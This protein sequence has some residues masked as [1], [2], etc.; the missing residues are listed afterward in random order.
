MDNRNWIGALP[1][2]AALLLS[3]ACA[4]PEAAPA[5]EM[6]AAEQLSANAQKALLENSDDD[7]SKPPFTKETV[8][9][10]NSIVRRSL[11]S[12]EAFDVL[13]P[14]LAAA[15]QSNDTARVTEI[16][17]QMAELETSATTARTDFVAA[18][19]ALIASKEEHNQIVLDAMEQFVL[20]VPS[21]I[22]ETLAQQGE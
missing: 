6:D 18:K 5:P 11:D 8:I 13:V 22:A 14:E 3:T 12:L 7:R 16:T 19:K 4:Q 1:M 20:E 9:K 2:L 10:L 21:E 17:K 15:K